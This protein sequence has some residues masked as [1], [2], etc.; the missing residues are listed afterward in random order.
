MS[1]KHPGERDP[2]LV[3]RG[4]DVNGG[5]RRPSAQSDVS[6]GNSSFAGSSSL[7]VDLRKVAYKLSIPLSALLQHFQNDP[8]SEI[9]TKSQF[10]EP[11]RSYRVEIGVE[12]DTS[13]QV[14]QDPIEGTPLPSPQCSLK[15]SESYLGGSTRSGSDLGTAVVVTNQLQIARKDARKPPPSARTSTS[16]GSDDGS[17]KLVDIHAARDEIGK[18]YIA[19]LVR[20]NVRGAMMLTLPHLPPQGVNP[21]FSPNQNH[22]TFNASTSTISQGLREE[23]GESHMCGCFSDCFIS[24]AEAQ[25]V[26]HEST[27]HIGEVTCCD[28]SSCFTG[29]GAPTVIKGVVLYSAGSSLMLQVQRK[30]PSW[31]VPALLAAMVLGTFVPLLYIKLTDRT[32]EAHVTTTDDLGIAAASVWWSLSEFGTVTLMVLCSFLFSFMSKGK[33]AS[34]NVLKP[35]HD[36]VYGPLSVKLLMLTLVLSD[37]ARR[38]GWSFLKIQESNGPAYV[39]NIT[40][41][42]WVVLYKIVWNKGCGGAAGTTTTKSVVAIEMVATLL[43]LSGG[44][45]QGTTLD[46]FSEWDLSDGVAAGAVAGISTA[47]YIL[48]ASFMIPNQPI[49]GLLWLCKFVNVV[50]AFIVVNVRSQNESFWSHWTSDFMGGSSFYVVIL[51]SLMGVFRDIFYL[52]ALSAM[53]SATVASAMVTQNVFTLLLSHALLPS[54]LSFGDL[55]LKLSIPA[56]SLAVVGLCVCVNVVLRE[57]QYSEVDLTSKELTKKSAKP[58]PRLTTA[59]LRQQQ[60]SAKG[61][62]PIVWKYSPPPTNPTQYPRMYPPRNSFFTPNFWKNHT[63]NSMKYPPSLFIRCLLFVDRIH[64]KSASFIY[65]CIAY[66]FDQ[67]K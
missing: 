36:M 17:L 5:A 55:N 12:R 1:G 43:V 51:L 33:K 59:A 24:F 63:I 19:Y 2:L 65:R 49:L 9:I 57:V 54:H 29:T 4:A 58:P 48:S 30:I 39:L 23:E 53:H 35:L 34:T 3:P 11:D 61:D 32:D 44:V 14:Y 31:G 18:P 10:E 50:G 45:L 25:G 46:G 62:P 21:A 40:F 8:S 16:V 60:R 37:C 52:V 26:K 66:S 42:L 6:I 28:F 56:V 67:K 38:I 47:A 13:S 22:L 15:P 41:A 20:D 64:P 7:R 27:S